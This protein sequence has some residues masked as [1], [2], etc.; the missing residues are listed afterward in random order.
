M[1]DNIFIC[2]ICNKPFSSV[3]S[4]VSHIRNE[5]KPLSAKEYYDNYLK[6]KKMK[7]NV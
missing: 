4:F 5:H 6:K 7:I 3:F 2:K 1:S